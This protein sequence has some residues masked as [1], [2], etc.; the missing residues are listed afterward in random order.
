MESRI[1]VISRA[2]M[3]SNKN[4]DLLWKQNLMGLLVQSRPISVANSLESG[5]ILKPIISQNT[6]VGITL[7]ISSNY[8]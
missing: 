4:L 6:P 8:L 3:E 2:R 1:P 7:D 5:K